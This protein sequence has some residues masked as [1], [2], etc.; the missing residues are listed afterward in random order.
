MNHKLSPWS[1]WSSTI[2]MF[3]LSSG[4]DFSNLSKC[5]HLKYFKTLYNRS[6]SCI[7]TH[8]SESKVSINIIFWLIQPYPHPPFNN[9]L[10]KI[11]FY[12]TTHFPLIPVRVYWGLVLNVSMTDSCDKRVCGAETRSGNMLQ[13]SHNS[14]A[15]IRN[16]TGQIRN[17]SLICK[18]IHS[19]FYEKEE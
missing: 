5:K 18:L 1:S 14:K 13:S 7:L 3:F 12:Y 2:T 6:F 11:L 19:I 16:V 9:L 17:P 8:W 10:M 4:E 15:K